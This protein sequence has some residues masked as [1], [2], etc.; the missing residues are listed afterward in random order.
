MNETM[1]AG[2]NADVGNPAPGDAEEEEVSRPE[3]GEAEGAPGRILFSGAPGDGD[4]DL[5][6]GI[7]DEAAAVKSPGRGPPITVGRAEKTLGYGDNFLSL[8][9]W[10]TGRGRAIAPHWCGAAPHGKPEHDDHKRK[11]P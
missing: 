9:R 4:P 8:E 11:G 10:V 3:L 7:I 6:V 1:A 2:V 5:L